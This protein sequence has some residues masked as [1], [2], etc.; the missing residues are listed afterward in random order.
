MTEYSDRVLEE[1]PERVTKFLSGLG[2][3]AEI[4]T[5]M[6]TQAGMAVE[7]VNEGKDLLLSALA[8][9]STTSTAKDTEEAKAQRA[10]T[11]ELDAWDEPNFQR[12]KAI[13]DRHHPDASAYVFHDLSASQGPA[14][15]KGVATFLARLNALETG[16]DAARSA[17]KADDKKAVQLLAKRGITK[18]ERARL[19]ELVHVALGPTT[20]LELPDTSTAETTRREKLSKLKG[21]YDEWATS[22]HA[23]IKKRSHLIRLGL[24][25]RRSP[26]SE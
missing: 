24:A 13:L 10:A 19:Q 14:A 12:A 18:E 21:W 9:P 6:H 5:V 25:E 7:D 3:V 4:F 2:A 22:A 1:T 17:S 11:A 23:V 26:K 15:V 16:S 20:P 8:I